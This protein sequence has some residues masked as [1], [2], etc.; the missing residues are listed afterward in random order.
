V[1]GDGKDLDR[2]VAEKMAEERTRI[3]KDL[4]KEKWVPRRISSA[5]FDVLAE[6][7]KEWAYVPTREAVEKLLKVVGNNKFVRWQLRKLPIADRENLLHTSDNVAEARIETFVENQIMKGKKVSLKQV[8]NMLE[9]YQKY[10]PGVARTTA[11][12]IIHRVRN[13]HRKFVDTE[14]V[15]RMRVKYKI[16]PHDF[17]E[18]TKAGVLTP[19]T[20]MVALKVVGDVLDHMYVVSRRLRNI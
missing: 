11:K 13:R 15:N 6:T 20:P 14:N 8:A 2:R 5:A 17:V 19:S 12:R 16:A 10:V 9:V 7:G 1:A 4:G 18:L 3:A